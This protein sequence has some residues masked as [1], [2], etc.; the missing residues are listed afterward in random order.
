MIKKTIL[1]IATF[2]ISTSISS[3]A[4]ED[5][6]GTYSGAETLTVFDCKHKAVLKGGVTL[7]IT[8]MK[9]TTFKG[10]GTNM[11]SKFTFKGEIKDDQLTSKVKGKNK[12]GQTWDATTEGT[13]NGNKYAYSVNGKVNEAPNCKFTSDVQVMQK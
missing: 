10:N 13:L 2:F 11:D 1:I 7:N 9:G 3:A 12:W 4:P 5:I 8:E 6:K